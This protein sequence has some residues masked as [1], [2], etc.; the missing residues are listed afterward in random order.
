[1]NE[2]RR[3]QNWLADSKIAL[4]RHSTAIFGQKSDGTVL[5][6]TGFL[7]RFKGVVCVM[8][9]DHVIR[10]LTDPIFTLP[11]NGLPQTHSGKRYNSAI[12]DLGYFF[13]ATGSYLENKNIIEAADVVLDLVDPGESVFVYGYPSGNRHVQQGVVRTGNRLDFKSMTYLSVTEPDKPNSDLFGYSQPTIRW[14]QGEFMH[15]RLTKLEHS[16]VAQGFSGGPVFLAES[17]RLIGHV[18]HAS[19]TSLFYTPIVKS[20]Y[21]MGKEADFLHVLR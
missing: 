8:T 17:L 6:G 9:C 16:L 1:M 14:V 7:V 15:E 21:T 10:P 19:T 13:P 4:A 2:R 20:F 5:T 11:I 3:I 18:T 12:H